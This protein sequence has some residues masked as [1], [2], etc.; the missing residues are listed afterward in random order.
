MKNFLAIAASALASMF[1]VRRNHS[2]YAKSHQ[3][4]T[5][6]SKRGKGN[7]K[8]NVKRFHGYRWWSDVYNVE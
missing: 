7:T 4:D 3:E 2:V 8:Q 1:S 6:T 5:P